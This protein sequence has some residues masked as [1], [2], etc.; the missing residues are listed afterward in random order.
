MNFASNAHPSPKSSPNLGLKHRN[1]FGF[2]ASAELAYEITAPEQIPAVMTQIAEKKL[3]W[4]VLGGGSNVILPTVLPGATLLMN[5]AGQE[6]ISSDTNSTLIAVGGGVNWHDFVAWALENNLPGLENLALI[7]GTVGAAPIQNIGAYGVEIGEYIDS[8]DAYDANSHA[9]VTLTNE[10]CCF[11]YRDSYFKK[12]PQRFIV[13]KVVF[14]LP[15]QWQARVHYADLA[16]QFSEQSSPSPE[17]IFLAV[18]KIRTHKLPDPKVIG[19]AGSF[20]QNPIVP[21][22]QYETLLHKFPG[23][24]SYPDA[25]GKRKLAAGWLI[26]QCGFKGQRMG[27]VGV[28]E[29]QALVLVN[30]G[31]GTAQDILGLAKCIQEKVKKEFGVHLEIEPN[32]L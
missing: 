5:I 4:R 9:F 26:D 6:I 10:E 27:N 17:E 25:A 15:K 18:C 23:L 8:V 24:A 28:Y 16:K 11:A 12:N 31:N 30:H 22:E 3:S 1:T 14:R 19:N 20:F 2:E 21:N 32:I 7:P 29:N 13:T